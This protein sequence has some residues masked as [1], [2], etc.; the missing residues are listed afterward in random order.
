M[1]GVWLSASW[2]GSPRV[3]NA[4]LVGQNLQRNAFIVQFIITFLFSQKPEQ[5]FEKGEQTAILP[6][7]CSEYCTKRE[8][9]LTLGRIW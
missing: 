9:G 7:K 3:L 6:K 1:R 4:Q 8:M 5:E 2:A